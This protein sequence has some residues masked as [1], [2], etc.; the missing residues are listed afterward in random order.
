MIKK[1]FIIFTF[2]LIAFNI[3][4]VNANTVNTQESE[5]QIAEKENVRKPELTIEI[6]DMEESKRIEG[7]KILLENEEKNIY[8]EYVSDESG[9]IFAKNIEPGEY[10]IKVLE[11]AEEYIFEDTIYTK[12]IGED[13][14]MFYIQLIPVHH[15]MGDLLIECNNAGIVFEVVTENCFA[16]YEADANG[17]VYVRNLFTGKCT[18]TPYPLNGYVIGAPVETK[19]IEGET[20]KV[21]FMTEE[22]SKEPEDEKA[23]NKENSNTETE[24]KKDEN[25]NPQEE[26]KDNTKDET[27]SEKE[28]IADNTHEDTGKIDNIHKIPED[29][30]QTENI[31]KEKDSEKTEETNNER[32]EDNLKDNNKENEEIK[33]KRRNRRKYTTGK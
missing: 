19:I 32:V 4:K 23:E 11:G 28:E 5:I 15:K 22:T 10:K 26:T 27:N 24:D 21:S 12:E 14:D 8:N 1:V 18:V 9:I 29:T 2:V 13:P 31:N 25:N 16:T 33:E 3:A 6:R 7:V 17:K 20:C 30:N